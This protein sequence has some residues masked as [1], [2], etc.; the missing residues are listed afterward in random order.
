MVYFAFDISSGKNKEARQKNKKSKNIWFF[1]VSLYSHHTIFNNNYTHLHTTL[2]TPFLTLWNS[3]PSHGVTWHLERPCFRK[4]G[5][6]RIGEVQSMLLMQDSLQANIPV[7]WR[8]R[9]P[10]KDLMSFH[11]GVIKWNLKNCDGPEFFYM[12]PSLTIQG[13]RLKYKVE[14]VDWSTE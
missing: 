10:L 8:M 11:H 3:F 5:H 9:Q 4:K 2:Y 7:T 12:Q 1:T 13:K 6:Y 14:A